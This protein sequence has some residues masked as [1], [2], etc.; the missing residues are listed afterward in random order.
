[1][2]NKI[3]FGLCLSAICT[4]AFASGDGNF[5]AKPAPTS[6]YAPGIYVGV[7]GGVDVQAVQNGND[8]YDLLDNQ[9]SVN[10][11]R[12]NDIQ[13]GIGE[14]SYDSSISKDL[15]GGWAFRVYAGWSILKYLS[16]ES[17]YGRYGNSLSK[18]YEMHT[19]FSGSGIV[20]TPSPLP[21]TEDYDFSY[22]PTQAI[23]LMAKGILPFSN[24]INNFNLDLYV[25]A[26]AAY[27][28]TKFTSEANGVTKHESLSGVYPAVG[29][30]FE[31]HFTKNLSLD[32]SDTL[33][34]GNGK[35]SSGTDANGNIFADASGVPAVS[36]LALGLTYKFTNL[37][38]AV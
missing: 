29:L 6:N 37:V 35:I 11:K 21:R 36:F 13:S 32:L 15:V 3:L 12:F 22:A 18:G 14:F 34:I 24:F 1:M 8:L 28:W 25:K 2:F 30:G 26:G 17:G 9:K 31:Y 19:K 5:A 16:I 27:A 4:F 33:I 7:Q 20:F 10:D 38:P 23:D